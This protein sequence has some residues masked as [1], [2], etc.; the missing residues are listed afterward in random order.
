MVLLSFC[1]SCVCKWYWRTYEMH[2]VFFVKSGVTPA[3]GLRLWAATLHR[4]SSTTSS[5]F[6]CHH[7]AHTWSRSATRSI[8]P[9]LLVSPLLG[10]PARL[11]SFMSA[12][13]LHQRKWSHNL[14]LQYSTK[15]Q[16]T[17]CCQSLIAP[18]SDHPPSLNTLVI[19]IPLGECIDNT[20][21]HQ[22]RKERKIK[23]TNK[24]LKQVIKSQTKAKTRSI[25]PI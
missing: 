7:A 16:F 17:T 23:E 25:T 6:S 14:H 11:R 20:H 22:F 3:C 2:S 24:N 4:L 15:G 8:E 13:H 10:G 1:L 19:N 5:C 18:G 21:C 12:L 9:S